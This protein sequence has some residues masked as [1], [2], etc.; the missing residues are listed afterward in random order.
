MFVRRWCE[1][2]SGGAWRGFAYALAAMLAVLCLSASHAQ[3]ITYSEF[4]LGLWDHDTH[5]L[6]GKERGAD[7]NAEVILASPVTNDMLAT[8]PSWLLWALQPRP[9]LGGAINTAGD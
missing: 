5:F 9:T 3:N 4:K 8:A 6:E 2:R 1:T 7:I